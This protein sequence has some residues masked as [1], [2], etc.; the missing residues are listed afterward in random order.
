MQ[1]YTQGYILESSYSDNLFR[2]LSNGFIRV[3]AKDICQFCS[4]NVFVIKTEA[5]DRSFALLVWNGQ[6]YHLLARPLMCIR[7]CML[8]YKN[9][10]KIS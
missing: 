4:P 3:Y 6:G 10:K 8:P 7:C 1:L 2:C 9:R 5:S